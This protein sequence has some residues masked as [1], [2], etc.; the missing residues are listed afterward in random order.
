MVDIYIVTLF[1]S[2]ILAGL[3]E[4]GID[5]VWVLILFLVVVIGFRYLNYLYSDEWLYRTTVVEH[6][7][8]DDVFQPE[9]LSTAL[10]WL[11]SQVF[12]A[13]TGIFSNGQFYILATSVITI[14]LFVKSLWDYSN[15]FTFSIFL[16]ISMGYAF[17]AMNIVRQFVAVAILFYG[18]RY[19]KQGEFWKYAICVLVA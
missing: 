6:L 7:S 19:M 13:E 5:F 15:H 16:F 18:L 12:S 3:A 2:C 17:T 10:T 14:G 11:S 8:F 4:R 1:V 9:G